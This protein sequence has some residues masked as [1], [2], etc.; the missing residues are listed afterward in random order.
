MFDCI[1]VGAGPAGISA[2]LYLARANKKVLVLYYNE[3]QVEKAHKIDNYY[4]FVDGISGNDL[5]NN[6][7]KQAINLGVDVLQEEVLDIKID[8]D[9]H[10]QVNTLNNQYTS[11]TLIIATGNKKLRPNIKGIIEF[12][13]KGISY[14]AI[15]DGFFY[16]KKKLAVLGASEYAISEANELNNITDD[17]T[18]LSNGEKLNGSTKFNVI[19]KKIKEIKGDVK[20]RNV[21]FEDGSTFELDGLFIAIGSAGGIDFA[22]KLGLMVEN[23]NIVVDEN[24]KTIIDGLYACGN[25]T[26][27]LLQVGKA[28]YE[29]SMAGLSAIKYI[30]E[31]K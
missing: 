10:Y 20:I 15:C 22:K 16:R 6:G 7:I 5:Y 8:M 23:D 2:S 17:I 18:I 30:N 3:A 11:K 4:G 25:I 19:D 27:G 12:E 29:G 24:M 13:G 14:C 31:K 26:G 21:E 1:I 9:M 28:V